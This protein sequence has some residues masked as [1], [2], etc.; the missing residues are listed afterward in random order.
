MGDRITRGAIEAC[1]GPLDRLRL[2]L[3]GSV[4]AAFSLDNPV[5]VDDAYEADSLGTRKHGAGSQLGLHLTVTGAG[6]L[7]DDAQEAQTG[8]PGGCGGWHGQRTL[9]RRLSRSIRRQAFAQGYTVEC[10]VDRKYG[11]TTWWLM[12]REVK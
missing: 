6:R 11:S 2:W 4:V 7:Y 1:Y 5:H 3:P 8:Q 9:G 10:F 12:P